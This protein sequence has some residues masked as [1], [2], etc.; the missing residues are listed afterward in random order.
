MEELV[1]EIEFYKGGIDPAKQMDLP[2]TRKFHKLPEFS[3]I[4]PMLKYPKN[5]GS[6]LQS[7]MNHLILEV[8]DERE[9]RKINNTALARLNEAQKEIIVQET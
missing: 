2:E 7:D 3:P 4:K 5:T 9:R 1:E 6:T 8:G